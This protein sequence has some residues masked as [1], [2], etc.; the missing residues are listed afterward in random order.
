MATF[1]KRDARSVNLC[2]F[3]IMSICNFG[4]FIFCLIARLWVCLSQFLVIA[5]LVT[6]NLIVLT[7]CCRNTPCIV[8]SVEYRLA[9]EHKFPANNDDAK[10]AVDWAAKNKTV[11][12][13]LNIHRQARL[14]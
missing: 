8:A 6:F 14:M 7:N 5:Y 1:W 3:F 9:P 11:L 4:Y 10:C 2:S 12:G 13:K